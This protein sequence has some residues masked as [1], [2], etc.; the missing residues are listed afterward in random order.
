M[1]HAPLATDRN[2]E[3]VLAVDEA[4]DLILGN[5]VE[6]LERPFPRPAPLKPL[7]ILDRFLDLAG[8]RRHLQGPGWIVVR[9]FVL[10]LFL[11]LTKSHG[12]QEEQ[13]RDCHANHGRVTSIAKTAALREVPDSARSQHPRALGTA[14]AGGT[15]SPEV[16]KARTSERKTFVVDGNSGMQVNLFRKVVSF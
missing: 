14:R 4:D 9:D 5:G 16:R 2:D 10:V 12:R 6:R 15:K 13:D 7:E 1:Q 3:T 11:G 8:R